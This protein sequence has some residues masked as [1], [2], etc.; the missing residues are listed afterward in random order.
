[1]AAKLPYT[2]SG[3]NSVV[4]QHGAMNDAPMP[5]AI[6]GLSGRYP[7]SQNLDELWQNLRSR[8]DC[9]GEVDGTRWDTGYH[10]EESASAQRIY[11]KA[12][13]FL[14]RVDSFD[15]EF[16]GMSPR[17]A[18]QVDP[19]HRLLLELA[20]EAMEDAGI[21]P[22]DLAGTRT[23]V[24]VGIS[25]ND[26]ATLVGQTVD[27]YTNIGSALSIAANRVSYVFDL[28]GP[29]MSID[30]ACSSSLVALHQACRSIAAGDCS[31]ALV[32]GVNILGSMKLFM[33]FAQASML[34]PDG[35]CK[36]FDADGKG[37]V[38]AEGGGIA[39]LKPLAEAERDGDEIL[40][41][42]VGTSVN[43]DGKTMGMA[44]PSGEAQERLLRQIYT[45][46]NVAPKTSS[47]LRLTAQVRR[48]V[49]R[50]NA[51]PSAV[52]LALRAGTV[53]TALSAPSSRTSAILN[54]G[55]AWQA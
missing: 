20:W 18:R 3:D 36:S 26:Y 38:R 27:A 28:H 23:G 31:M 49:T 51:A 44:L 24:F 33:G 8:V 29:S 9:V 40:A 19:Q 42:I 30:T 15:A 34:S 1:M 39:I 17:E 4:N 54:Q 5:I 50:S 37:Y 52:C 32:G 46:C 48:R 10:V 16:F 55:P 12:G 6:V 7:K 11:T 21:V 45:Q 43:S 22:G 35:R 25:S 53:P 47:M 13:G 14:D 2:I 41:V